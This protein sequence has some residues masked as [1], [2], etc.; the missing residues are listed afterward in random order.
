MEARRPPAPRHL[1]GPE[2]RALLARN[3]L[4]IVATVGEGQPYATPLIYGYQNDQL[5]FVTGTG[6]KTRNM[7][8]QPLVCVTVIETEEHAKKWQ[9]VIA[10]GNVSWLTDEDSVTH[11]LAV[12]KEQYPGQSTRSSAGAAA[13]TEAGYRVGVVEIQRM[14]GR[15][16]GY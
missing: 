12:M 3:Y 15:A 6:R 13:L 14:S 4:A 8:E 16:Q 11:A 10:Y 7:D 1:N 5:F 2:C 9:S